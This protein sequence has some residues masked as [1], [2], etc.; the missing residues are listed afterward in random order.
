MVGHVSFVLIIPPSWGYYVQF[1]LTPRYRKKIF[2]AIYLADRW[3]L[4]CSLFSHCIQRK[5]TFLNSPGSPSNEE[6]DTRFHFR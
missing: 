3:G 5:Q 4:L 2:V 1:P 6:A